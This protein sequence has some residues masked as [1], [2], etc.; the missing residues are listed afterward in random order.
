MIV[1]TG[2]IFT[3]P[4]TLPALFARLQALC[5]PSR[6]ED[7]CLF[8]HMGLEDA[9]KGIIMAMEGWRDMEALQTHLALPAIASLLAD[10]DG[11]YTNQVTI[12]EV[13]S[14]QKF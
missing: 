5:E 8:Y 11:K 10:F 12:H 13:T 6:A 2:Q 9:E 14:S 4:K 1:V 7:G 3:D